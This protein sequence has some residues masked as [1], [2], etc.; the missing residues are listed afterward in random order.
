[1]I[2]VGLIVLA[3]IVLKFIKRRIY[4]KFVFNHYNYNV[5][6]LERS[7]K[8]YEDALGLHELRRKEAEDGSFILVYLSDGESA[9]SLELTWLRD[10]D[11]N[12]D[13]GDNEVHLAFV[14]DDYQNAYQKHKEM[15]CI[16][17]ENHE[18]GI[19]FIS[20]PD[21]YWIEIVPAR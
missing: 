14:T 3:F 11:R 5:F 21:G 17:F 2:N 8:F 4:M 13:L 1:M 10:W 7:L 12:Y 15:G 18:M 19:Y 16:C 9:F 20:D 6:D